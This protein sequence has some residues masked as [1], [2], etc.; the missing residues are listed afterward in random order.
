MILGALAAAIVLLAVWL[1]IRSLGSSPTHLTANTTSTSSTTSTSIDTGTTLDIPTVTSEATT[2]PA[3][4]TTTPAP[5]ATTTPPTTVVVSPNGAFLQPV[6]QPSTQSTQPPTADCH[7]L[8]DTGWTVAQCNTFNQTGPSGTSV[9]VALIEKKKGSGP[10]N[11]WRA[12][13]LHFS[14]GKGTWLRDLAY[15]DDNGVQVVTASYVAKDMKG[16]G[17]DEVV[18]GFRLQG[19]GS[20]LDYDIVDG[21]FSGVHVGAHR[22]LARGQAKV[23]AGGVSDWQGLSDGSYQQ[24]KVGWNGAAW[25]LTTGPRIG[26]P[27]AGDF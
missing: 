7:S 20:Y 24:S 22:S 1:L 10:S 21:M 6:P 5:P 3:P 2:V 27:G 16:D 17:F 8:G 19:S 12:Y 18:F 9:V 14:Q 26:T 4:A 11:A 25:V 13:M 15:A 23:T